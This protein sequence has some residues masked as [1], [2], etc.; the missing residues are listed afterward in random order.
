MYYDD[1]DEN[2]ERRLFHVSM[3]AFHLQT[4]VCDRQN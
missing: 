3:N 2:D 1:D 4:K